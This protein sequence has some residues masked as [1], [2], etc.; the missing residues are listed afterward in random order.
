VRVR[1]ALL[2]RSSAAALS[3]A[4]SLFDLRI[5]SREAA[6]P[7]VIKQSLMRFVQSAGSGGVSLRFNTEYDNTA[8]LSVSC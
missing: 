6:R 5:E 7:F 4:T 2:A 8:L 1:E 3:S